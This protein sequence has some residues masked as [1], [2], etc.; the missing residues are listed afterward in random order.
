MRGLILLLVSMALV[1]VAICGPPPVQAGTHFQDCM[2]ASQTALVTV[3]NPA[4]SPGVVQVVHDPD[5]AV[6]LS[7]ADVNHSEQTA[8]VFRRLGRGARWLFG[9]LRGG[10]C[11]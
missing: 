1:A 7:A 5:P 9:R 6:S 11:G 3:E 10:G 8:C 4:A 2:I